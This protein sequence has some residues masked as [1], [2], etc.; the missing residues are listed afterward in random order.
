MSILSFGDP[1]GLWQMLHSILPSP[2]GMCDER[3]S[4]DF[5]CAWQRPHVSATL[6]FA[7]LPRSVSLCITVWQSVH[8]TFRDSCVLPF[9]SVRAVFSWQFR[10]AAFR[11]A[12]GVF[13]FLLK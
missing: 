5:F 10:Q 3:A 4:C 11:S 12:T 6:A 7:R 1:C 13:V 2:M 8:A 9:Q